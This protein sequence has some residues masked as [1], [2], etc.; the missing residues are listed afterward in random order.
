MFAKNN[1]THIVLLDTQGHT[2]EA[3]IQSTWSRQSDGL[4][5]ETMPNR[6][7]MR[8]KIHRHN[9]IL[10]SDALPD[11]DFVGPFFGV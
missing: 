8:E 4:R 5:I 11:F 7:Q 6:S 9:N 10:I 3:S 1:I 2:H